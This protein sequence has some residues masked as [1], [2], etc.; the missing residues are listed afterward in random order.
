M[1]LVKKSTI[2]FKTIQPASLCAYVQ[3][4]PGVVLLD[5]RTPEEFAVF[6]N[7]ELARWGRVVRLSGARVE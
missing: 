1:D 6:I 3:A 5:V 2:R 7:T 4:H